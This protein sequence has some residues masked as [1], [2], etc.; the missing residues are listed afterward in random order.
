MNQSPSTNVI[1]TVV[2]DDGIPPL[3]ATNAFTI[4]VSGPY[5]GIN[6]SDP[7]Q[8]AADPDGDGLSNLAELALGTNPRNSSD[9]NS[10]VKTSVLSIAGSPYVSMRFNRRKGLT[11][12]PLQYVPE[13]S[14]DGDTWF[15]D[16]GHVLEVSVT[17]VDA[18]FDSVLVRD[19]VPATSP[20]PRFI[21]LRIVGH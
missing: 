12:I 20:A 9:G 17:P 13:V 15:S 21:R 10:T 7:S 14:G 16:S 4:V 6:L 2:T 1:T 5:D 3:S 8:A 11:G 19:L 18:Q